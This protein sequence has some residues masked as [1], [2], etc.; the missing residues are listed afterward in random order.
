MS[1]EPPVCPEPVPVVPVDVPPEV[2]VDVPPAGV[3]EVPVVPEV[4]SGLVVDM[5]LSCVM[6]SKL[7]VLCA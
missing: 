2:P 3:P 1:A 4:L 5:M 7:K 6:K